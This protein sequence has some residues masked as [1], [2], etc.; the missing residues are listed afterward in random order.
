MQSSQKPKR[1]CFFW[2]CLTLGISF[3]LFGSCTGFVIY[4]TYS[5]VK[6]YTSD[7]QANIPIYQSTPEEYQDVKNRIDNFLLAIKNN[8]TAELNLT[9]NDLN[10]LVNNSQERGKYYFYIEGDEITIHNSFPLDSIPGFSGRYLNNKYSF[11]IS[12]ENGMLVMT[13]IEFSIDDQPLPSD[14]KL[15]EDLNTKNLTKEIN[16][17]ER[18]QDFVENIQEIYVENDRLII[19]R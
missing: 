8:Q 2:G 17:N 18:I 9:A 3:L 4:Q 5:I 10:T 12:M 13:P 7:K 14:I 19:K 6:P 15:M 16:K 1:G 11:K